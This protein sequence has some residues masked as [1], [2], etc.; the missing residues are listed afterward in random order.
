MIQKIILLL[1][2]PAV[3]LA[4]SD[5]PIEE[6]RTEAAAAEASAHSKENS[7]GQ[8]VKPP[9][10]EK[11]NTSPPPPLSPLETPPPN[12]S[13]NPAEKTK[14]LGQRAG[15][16]LEAGSKAKTPNDAAQAAASETAPPLSKKEQE[17]KTAIKALQGRYITGAFIQGFHQNIKIEIILNE[18]EERPVL[19]LAHGERTAC[20]L[21]S[22]EDIKEN[23]SLRPIEAP[24]FWFW[25][26]GRWSAV[27]SQPDFSILIPE[28]NINKKPYT[29]TVQEIKMT[30]TAN[31]KFTSVEVDPSSIVILTNQTE[32]STKWTY[33][34]LH[35]PDYHEE[36]YSI[37]C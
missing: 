37:E 1:W 32:P 17:K 35:D 9:S 14:T 2:L 25:S 11:E 28:N 8:N 7:T 24:G 23:I 12:P 4:C 36:F 22:P 20:V 26:K 33:Q 27:F 16:P 34:H 5:E 15:A 6:S 30:L 18:S 10:K 19:K 3:F 13:T 31:K 21:M 29:L